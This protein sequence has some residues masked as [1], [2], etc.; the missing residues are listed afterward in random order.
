MA[1]GP[2]A[3]IGR[4]GEKQKKTPETNLMICGLRHRPGHS[5]WGPT[6]R[7]GRGV[8]GQY[9]RAHRCRCQIW[10]RAKEFATRCYQQAINGSTWYTYICQPSAD[11][12]TPRLL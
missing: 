3:N 7:R 6:G 1:S 10:E 8:P 11:A 4:R 2:V 12:G 5:S 9:A